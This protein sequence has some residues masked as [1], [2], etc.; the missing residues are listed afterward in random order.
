MPAVAPRA[1]PQPRWRRAASLL[2]RLST[3][4]VKRVTIELDPV[5]PPGIVVR[6]QLHTLPGD[7]PRAR[8]VP[9][10]LLRA[11]EGDARRLIAGAD[12][13]RGLVLPTRVIEGLLALVKAPEKRSR[14]VRPGAR[15]GRAEGRPGRRPGARGMGKKQPHPADVQLRDSQ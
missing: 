6:R 15:V 1:P 5:I 14:E 12:F 10:L 11:T 7:L 8:R 13:E 3:E 4:P 9:G 2:P